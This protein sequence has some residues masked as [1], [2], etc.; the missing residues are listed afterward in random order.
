MTGLGGAGRRQE[1]PPHT[2]SRMRRGGKSETRRLLT[3]RTAELH[4]TQAAAHKAEHEAAD[5]AAYGRT[6]PSLH[7][8]SHNA[9]RGHQADIQPCVGFPRNECIQRI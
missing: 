8:W 3:A 1:R 9:W 6:M 4:R 7:A 2:R 5:R